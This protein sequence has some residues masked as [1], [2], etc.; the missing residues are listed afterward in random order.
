MAAEALPFGLVKLVAGVIPVAM[1]IRIV[2]PDLFWIDIGSSAEEC[3]AFDVMGFVG[4]LAPVTLGNIVD[5][6][7]LVGAVYWMAHLRDARWPR[8][9]S[10]FLS[11]P[12]GERRPRPGTA[13]RA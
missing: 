7:M 5:G 12:R 11:R 2:A 1:L 9:A 3:V 8:P 6:T 13:P 10:A 4:H